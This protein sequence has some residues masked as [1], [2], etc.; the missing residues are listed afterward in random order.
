MNPIARPRL[1]SR[2]YIP[3]AISQR[4]IYGSFTWCGNRFA[5]AAMGTPRTPQ[6]VSVD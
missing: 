2:R 3:M 4:A 6:I 5:K 1:F